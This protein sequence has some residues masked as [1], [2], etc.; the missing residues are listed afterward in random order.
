[1]SQPN[2]NHEPESLLKE[3]PDPGFFSDFWDFLK[4]SQKWW[5]LPLLVVFMLLGIVMMLAKTAVAPFI[6]TL[7]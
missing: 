2:A 3:A 5:M 1:M 7:Y 6:Y 4:M